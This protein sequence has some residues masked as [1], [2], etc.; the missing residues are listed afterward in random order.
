MSGELR[1][2]P[3]TVVAH[4]KGSEHR[5]KA[6]MLLIS[7]ALAPA[8]EDWEIMEP[9]QA[10]PRLSANR[11]CKRRDDV[12]PLPRASPPGD[13]RLSFASFVIMH[14]T[15]PVVVVMAAAGS[16]S[17][18]TTGE[19]GSACC[20]SGSCGAALSASPGCFASLPS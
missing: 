6:S 10:Q 19:G 4:E 17:A 13:R 5:P 1:G 8:S 2:Y 11:P 20:C 14:H 12:R 15:W 16:P 18:G 3:C 9:Y 7:G